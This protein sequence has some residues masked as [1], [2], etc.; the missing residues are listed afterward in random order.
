MSSKLKSWLLLSVIFVVG[1][2]TGSTLTVGLA[3]HFMHPPGVRDMKRHW[4]TYLTRELNLTAEQQAKIQPIVADAVTRIHSLHRDEVERDSQIFKAADDQISPL[5]TPGQK[6]EL[7]KMESD[8][9]KK[10][11]DHMR[12]WAPPQDGR[13]PPAP[14][15]STDAAP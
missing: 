11:S 10:F 3:P 4:M 6:M 15:T 14:D 1:I 2:I 12:R 9:E 8:R 7:Q 5:L 13:M